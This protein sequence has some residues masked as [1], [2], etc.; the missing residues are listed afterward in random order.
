M[1]GEKKARTLSVVGSLVSGSSN[2]F[3]KGT[4]F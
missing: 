1:S 2:D 4:R 3:Y